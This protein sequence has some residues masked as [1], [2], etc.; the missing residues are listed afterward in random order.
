[1]TGLPGNGE[2]TI[3]PCLHIPLP[4]GFEVSWA[5]P[6]PLGRGLCFGSTDGKILFA[7][8]DGHPFPGAIPGK[9]SVF[10]EAINGVI[11]VGTWA[12]VSTRADVNFWPLPGTEGGTDHG[13]STPYGAHGV[14]TTAEGHVIAP[15]GRNGIMVVSPPFGPES[16]VM[17]VGDVKDGLYFYRAI[18]LRSQSGV[19]VIAC[20]ARDAGVAAGPFSAPPRTQPMRNVMFDALDVIDISPLDSEAFPLAVAALSRDGSIILFRDVLTD[21]KPTTM[22]FKKIQ[23]MAYRLLSCG[24]EIYV[25]TNRALY[26]LSKLAARFLAQELREGVVTQILT[27]SMEA[28]DANLAGNKLLVVMPDEVRRFD[29][30]WIHDNV[31]EEVLSPAAQEYRSAA[32]SP[33]LRVR[34]VKQTTRSLAVA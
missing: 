33:A 11:R 26:A 5:G 15:L 7:D 10:E 17:A 30:D 13:W 25:L 27:I 3:V 31:P 32:F 18:S 14:G 22:K 12:V 1:M 19:D 6:S 2:G 29:T 16:S 8:E 21:D 20:A 24:G 9:G 23:G 34:E 28:V 4:E